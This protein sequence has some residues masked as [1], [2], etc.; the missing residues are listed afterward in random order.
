[1]F[2]IEENFIIFEVKISQLN[3]GPEPIYNYVSRVIATE[4]VLAGSNVGSA[5]VKV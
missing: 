5:E 4:H 3:V 2:S 1:M